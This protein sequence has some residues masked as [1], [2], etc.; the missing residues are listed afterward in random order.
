MSRKDEDRRRWEGGDARW[1][2]IKRVQCALNV[3]HAALW[4]SGVVEWR[5]ERRVAGQR[6][7]CDDSSVVRTARNQ[8][9]AGVKVK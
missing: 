6:K 5:C 7:S 9:Q 3:P 8:Q 4:W 1:Q 2:R